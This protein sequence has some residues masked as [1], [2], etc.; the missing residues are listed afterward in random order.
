MA[1]ARDNVDDG[2]TQFTMSFTVPTEGLKPGHTAS[3]LLTGAHVLEAAGISNAD[4]LNA[5]SVD[6]EAEGMAGAG[7]T[8]VHSLRGAINPT[9][10]VHEPLLLDT[11]DAVYHSDIDAAGRPA[12]Q[13]ELFHAKGLGTTVTRTRLTLQ[14][15]PDQLTENKKMIHKKIDPKWRGFTQSDVL[16]GVHEYG[17]DEDGVPSHYLVTETGMN[18]SRSAMWN[19]LEINKDNSKLWNGAYTEAKLKKHNYKHEGKPARLMSAAHVEEAAAALG[20]SLK[21]HS[22]FAHGLGVVVTNK[23]TTTS[24]V[25]T[26]VQITVNRTP[27]HPEKGLITTDAPVDVSA[28]HVSGWNGGKGPAKAA[29][30]G[31]TISPRLVDSGFDRKWVQAGHT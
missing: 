28:A 2:K 29:A 15:S 9:T 6:V 11:K 31:E 18:G 5:Q 21:Q 8:V 22:P 20:K 19:L 1:A 12:K 24:R 4:V 27:L 16:E 25:P 7:I 3:R 14:P 13:S 23:G 10:R 30:T 26:T 17:V